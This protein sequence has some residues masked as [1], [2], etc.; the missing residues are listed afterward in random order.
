MKIIEVSN[1]K[2][3]ILTVLETVKDVLLVIPTNENK[4][5]LI[6]DNATLEI[7]NKFIEVISVKDLDRYNKRELIGYIKKNNLT[8]IGRSDFI[9]SYID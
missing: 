2:E 5:I 8:L 4:A 3:Y 7:I 1:E 9:S 6:C